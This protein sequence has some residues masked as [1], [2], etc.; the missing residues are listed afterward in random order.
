ML[1]KILQYFWGLLVFATVVLTLPV[2]VEEGFEAWLRWGGS[3][4]NFLYPYLGPWGMLIPAVLGVG[5][6]L[7][8][9]PTSRNWAKKEARDMAEILVIV[10]FRR[11]LTL[12]VILLIGYL[13]FVSI[14]PAVES[15][16]IERETERVVL[17]LSPDEF[18]RAVV[19]C[20]K[21]AEGFYATEEEMYNFTAECLMNRQ[22][23]EQ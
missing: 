15:I 4:V 13:L 17:D 19:D 18:A 22:G 7:V 23:I 2:A 21:L 5:W 6:L 12:G 20:H 3:A 14:Q 10:F 1:W 16:W 8:Y 11:P 9:S